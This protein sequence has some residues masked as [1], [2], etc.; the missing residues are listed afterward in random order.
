MEATSV[1]SYGH[2]CDARAL[3]STPSE[4]QRRSKVSAKRTMDASGRTAHFIYIGP[5]CTHV[6]ATKCEKPM[7]ASGRCKGMFPSIRTRILEGMTPQQVRAIN[8]DNV[9]ITCILWCQLDPSLTIARATR[10]ANGCIRVQLE[11]MTAESRGGSFHFHFSQDPWTVSSLPFSR[12][13]TSD[14]LARVWRPC[15]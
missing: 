11:N 9:V 4:H 12:C 10:L 15:H 5:L 6:I 14:H 3:W 8:T 2:D 7:R 1:T 13:G